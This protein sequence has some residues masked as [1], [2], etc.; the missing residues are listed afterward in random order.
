M[1]SRDETGHHRLGPSTEFPEDVPFAG[2]ADWAG[3]RSATRHLTGLGHRDIAMI[4]GPGHLYCQARLDGHRSAL[5]TAGLPVGAM[6]SGTWIWAAPI[7]V[8]PTSPTPTCGGLTDFDPREVERC[9]AVIT[10]EQA[11]CLAEAL[12]MSVRAD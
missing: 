4:S 7:C 6:V 10:A 9:G 11:V 5:Q 12:H 3:G 8:G 2:A 1:S